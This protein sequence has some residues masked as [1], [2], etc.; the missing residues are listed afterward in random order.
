V[1]TRPRPLPGLDD[2]V[3]WGHVA[4]GEL[5]L[6]RCRRCDRFRYP[7]APCCPGCLEADAEWAPVSGR[8]RAVSWVRFHRG[9]FPTLSPPYVV[10][11]VEVEEGPLMIG[12][13]DDDAA[14][15]LSVGAPLHVVFEDCVL[16][17]GTPF[18]VP[19]WK[20]V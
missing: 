18:V 10:V 9:Y 5:R 2:D 19:Q 1:R 8:G 16:E 3:F 4:R 20:L 6:Q 13:L 17:D 12:N 11:A 15:R 7:P 14:V